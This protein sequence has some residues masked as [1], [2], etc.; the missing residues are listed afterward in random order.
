MGYSAPPPA[1]SCYTHH[2]DL[3]VRVFG[4]SYEE[5]VGDAAAFMQFQQRRIQQVAHPQHGGARFP[6]LTPLLTLT[7]Y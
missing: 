1:S 6:R 2:E 3:I 7:P 5:F 4:C